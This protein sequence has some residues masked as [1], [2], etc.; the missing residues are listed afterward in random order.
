MNRLEWKEKSKDYKIGYITGCILTF[1][2]GLISCL[3]SYLFPIIAIP[4]IIGIVI[5]K[6]IVNKRVKER[7]NKENEIK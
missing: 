5:L 3:L 2:L 7:K 4:L 1:F 6:L